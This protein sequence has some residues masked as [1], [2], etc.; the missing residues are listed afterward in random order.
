LPKT[1]TR[2]RSID[3]SIRDTAL[4]RGSSVVASLSIIDLGFALHVPMRA[5][6]R[7]TLL[8][9]I[10]KARAWADALMTGRIGD[11]DEIARAEN[12][13]PRY[14][15]MLLPLAFVAP[16]IVQAVLDQKSEGVGDVR[17]VPVHVRVADDLGAAA[18]VD[19]VAAG[20]IGIEPNRS[21]QSFPPTGL[22]HAQGSNR[23]GA[24][25]E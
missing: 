16:D 14:V 5:D 24:T 3:Q 21:R 18:R 10:A 19:R 8:V 6:T 17:C 4:H 23:N 22:H 7:L 13:T 2:H 12:R 20:L 25:D 15:R 1:T 11:V 9:A